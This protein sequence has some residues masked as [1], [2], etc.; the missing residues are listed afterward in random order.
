VQSGEI[1]RW[2]FVNAGS[3]PRTLMTLR[4]YKFNDPVDVYDIQGRVNN[5]DQCLNDLS[6][7]Q[8]S[9]NCFVNDLGATPEQMYLIARDGIYLYGK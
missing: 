6:G 9:D 3:T 7:T 8:T 4:F 2:R 5:I 1:Q